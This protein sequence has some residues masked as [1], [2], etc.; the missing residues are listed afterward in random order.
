[1]KSCANISVNS[2]LSL[3]SGL[4]PGFPFNSACP[5]ALYQSSTTTYMVVRMLTISILVLIGVLSFDGRRG[6]SHLGLHSFFVNFHSTSDV[7]DN[8]FCSHDDTL[9]WP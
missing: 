5:L 7:D 6:T 8:V 3:N 9:L 2:S 1:M 4:A